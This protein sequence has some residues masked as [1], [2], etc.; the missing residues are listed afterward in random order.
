MSLRPQNTQSLLYTD[1]KCHCSLLSPRRSWPSCSKCSSLVNHSNDGAGEPLL[2][3][4]IPGHALGFYRK[5]LLS[6]I[7]NK[8]LALILDKISCRLVSLYIWPHLFFLFQEF[9]TASAYWW[10]SVTLSNALSYS[11]PLLLQAMPKKNVDWWRR[12]MS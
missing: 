12:E 8:P 10:P 11:S 6:R 4:Y 2:V 1:S 9:L 3:F 5:P 7:Q